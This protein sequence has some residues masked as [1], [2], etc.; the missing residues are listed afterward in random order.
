MA[1]TAPLLSAAARRCSRSAS[2]VVRRQVIDSHNLTLDGCAAFREMPRANFSSSEAFEAVGHRWRIRWYPNGEEEIGWLARDGYTSLFL[3]LDNDYRTTGPVDFRFS[4]LDHAGCPSRATVWLRHVFSSDDRGSDRWKCQ[5]FHYFMKWEDIQKSG[6]L[7][8]DRFTVRCD[9]SSVKWMETDETADAGDG[10]AAPVAQRV[11]VPPSNL[12]AHLSDL[13]W[14]KQGVDVAIDV[15]GE[16]FEAH[17]WLLKARAPVLEAELLAATKEK[18]KAPGGGARRR[19][20]IEGME[21]KVFK[22]MLHFVYTDRL[23][24]MGERETVAMAQGLLAAAHRYKIERLK[25]M[26]EEMLCKRINVNTVAA[27]M[28]VAEE[29]GCHNL[30]AACLEFIGRPGNAKA[31]MASEGFEKVKA[32]CLPLMMELVVMKKLA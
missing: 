22:A 19:M 13:L 21:A 25:L 31:V 9:I 24:E 27:T 11:V 6:C 8:D 20:E 15:A 16:T 7:K 3:E 14:K 17:G 5:G 12:H 26:C 23:P 1:T 29:H 30:K 4:L 28:V 32:S 2:A 18:E 10:T